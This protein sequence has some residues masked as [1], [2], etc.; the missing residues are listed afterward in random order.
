MKNANLRNIM[1]DYAN[2]VNAGVRRE[3]LAVGVLA[4]LVWL[5]SSVG[6]FSVIAGKDYSQ[7]NTS[8]AK[9]LKNTVSQYGNVALIVALVLLGMAVG[10]GEFKYAESR[11]EAK[12]MAKYII[13][14]SCKN[15]DSSQL[16]YMA[17]CVLA[18]MSNTERKRVL[19]M[20]IAL[21]DEVDKYV[22]KA[23][24]MR[25]TRS[26]QRRLIYTAMIKYKDEVVKMIEHNQIITF[27][28]AQSYL[29]NNPFVAFNAK[30]K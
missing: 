27:M 17:D 8:F 30:G 29:S 22:V 1:R 18:A 21:R 10:S 16:T 25:I 4:S 23:M 9:E 12:R 5:I 19:D 6:V 26:Q 28:A 14:S 2:L 11:Q 7:T 20:G 15:V 24:A 13:K 3:A